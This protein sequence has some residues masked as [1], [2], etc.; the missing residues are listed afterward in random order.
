MAR[1][2]HERYNLPVMHTETNH[3]EPEAVP[4]L[5]KT[6]ANIRQLRHD[7]VPVCGMTWYSLTDQIDWDTALREK[8]DR[9]NALGLFDLDRNLRPVGEAYRR[10]IA[11]WG[12]MPLLP[13]GPLTLV[14]R[15]GEDHDVI[16]EG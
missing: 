1:S 12:H 13:R 8:N 14:G 3:R 16:N 7:D 11:Q 15:F 2:Y 9:I 6:W 10:L 4:W 5:W